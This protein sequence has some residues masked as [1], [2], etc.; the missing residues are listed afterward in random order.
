LGSSRSRSALSA[1]CAR[2]LF[3]SSRRLGFGGLPRAQ[4][5]VSAARRFAQRRCFRRLGSFALLA[6]FTLALGSC[7]FLRAHFCFRSLSRRGFGG[8]SRRA[9]LVRS[10]RRVGQRCSPICHFCRVAGFSLLALVT[11]FGSFCGF[12]CPDILVRSMRRFYLGQS[13]SFFGPSCIGG[14]LLCS[15]LTRKPFGLRRFPRPAVLLR[16][17]RRFSRSLSQPLFEASR[18]GGLLSFAFLVSRA[19]GFRGFVRTAFLVSETLAL[20][21]CNALSLRSLVRLSLRVRLTSRFGLSEPQGLCRLTLAQLLIEQ[22]KRA[23]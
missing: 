16:L 15:L 2:I 8:F 6:L 4:L 20:F 12:A 18:L 17:S 9:L 23:G 13:S 7:G 10:A 11:P 3:R 14:Q 19:L 21:P 1:S 5:F 22:R